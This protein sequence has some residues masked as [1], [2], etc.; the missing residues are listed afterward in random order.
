MSKE[1]SQRMRNF[2]LRRG[3]G[4]QQNGFSRRDREREVS[5]GRGAE[6]RRAILC[7]EVF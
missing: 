4:P 7:H 3:M 5:W 1:H 6:K 2:D